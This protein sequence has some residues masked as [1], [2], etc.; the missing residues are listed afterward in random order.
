MKHNFKDRK[1]APEYRISVWRVGIFPGQTANS[2]VD[3]TTTQMG[4][5]MT[6]FRTENTVT[7]MLDFNQNR[8]QD[9]NE[10]EWDVAWCQRVVSR[11]FVRVPWSSHHAF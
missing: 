11:L 9:V 3:V 8:E 1:N 6:I 2:V 10:F 4:F 5:M 7:E